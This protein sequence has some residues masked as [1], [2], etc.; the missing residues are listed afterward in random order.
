MGHGSC[1]IQGAVL[2]GGQHCGVAQVGCEGV[3]EPPEEP[4]NILGGKS[5]GVEEDTGSNAERVGA[6]PLE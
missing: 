1:R 6:P 3:A 5:H 2:A 4:L